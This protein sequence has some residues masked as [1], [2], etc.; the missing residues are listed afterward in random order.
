[1]PRITDKDLVV[2]HGG[3]YP[4]GSDLWRVVKILELSVVGGI[5]MITYIKTMPLAPSLEEPQTSTIKEFKKKYIRAAP[6]QTREER[7]QEYKDYCKS[8][9]K[10]PSDFF[11]RG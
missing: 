9:G 8:V 10:E 6:A 2:G 5:Q 7:R 3:F 11:N 1:M 4:K